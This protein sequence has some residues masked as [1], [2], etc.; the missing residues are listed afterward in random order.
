M[1]CE[2]SICP[3]GFASESVVVFVLQS[4]YPSHF[5]PVVAS[6]SWQSR[7]P[8]YSPLLIYPPP[9][10][11]EHLPILIFTSSVS[12][13]R[14]ASSC[15]SFLAPLRNFGWPGTGER[16]DA[17]LAHACSSSSDVIVDIASRSLGSE[18]GYRFKPWDGVVKAAN[19]AGTG[20]HMAL[21]RR[22]RGPARPREVL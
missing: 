21:M 7:A 17:L 13:L 11:T 15:R 20:H 16:T 10:L 12:R 18:A 4:L 1:D 8:F 14:Q 6:V 2:S 19:L 22:S 9:K 5:H 3:L